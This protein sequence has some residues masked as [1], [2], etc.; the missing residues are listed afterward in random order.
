LQYSPFKWLAL[1]AKEDFQWRKTMSDELNF[2]SISAITN[3]A[4]MTA[5]FKLPAR[6]QLSTDATVY[7]RRGYGSAEL[8]TT[9]WVWN[10]RISW[11]NKS[12]QWLFALDGFD[13]LKQLSAVN[14]SVNAQGRTVTYMNVLPRYM[15]FHVQYKF[16]YIPKRKL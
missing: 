14:Y 2:T 1:T 16:N 8:N 3:N 15:M 11:T 10:A 6:F 12:G 4:G 7:A 9:D 5:L 13:I